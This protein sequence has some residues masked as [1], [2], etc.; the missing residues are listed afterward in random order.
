MLFENYEMVLHSK[1]LQV[2]VPFLLCLYTLQRCDSHTDLDLGRGG[3]KSAPT[4][5]GG[6]GWGGGLAGNYLWGVILGPQIF[7]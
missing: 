2:N 7:L 3:R 4:N 1:Y 5:T 6:R